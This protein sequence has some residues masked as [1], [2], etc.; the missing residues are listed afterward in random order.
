MYKAARRGCLSHQRNFLLMDSINKNQ[1]E[2][3]YKNLNSSEAISKMKDLIGEAKSCFFCTNKA[4]GETQGVRPMGIQKV[5]D[6]GNLWFLSARDS[7]KNLEITSDP[8]VKLYFQGSAHSDFLHLS[9][10][11]SITYDKA[12]IKDL[13]E[14][15]LKTW[16]TEGIEDPRISVIQVKPTEGYYW[17]TK[18]GHIIA[19]MK[20]LFGAAVGKTFDDSIEGKIK[21]S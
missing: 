17:D 9:G 20:M 18:H 14:P 19:G 6:Q 1:T 5:D 11:A 8:S 4:T 7:H 3:N 16:F 10:N 13:W 12:I 15:V 2:E 21:V